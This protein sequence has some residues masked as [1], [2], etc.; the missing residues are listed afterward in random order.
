MID[1]I[2]KQTGADTSPCLFTRRSPRGSNDFAIPGRLSSMICDFGDAPKQRRRDRAPSTGQDDLCCIY[3]VCIWSLAVVIA[4]N[5]A[6]AETTRAAQSSSIHVVSTRHDRRDGPQDMPSPPS[7][8]CGSDL[9]FLPHCRDEAN[10]D[11]RSRQRG[12]CQVAGTAQLPTTKS[13]SSVRS[14][15]TRKYLMIVIIATACVF[16]TSQGILILECRPLIRA[17]ECVS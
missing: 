7:P 15:S 5:H 9:P 14:L 13:P 1:S 6:T 3:Q 11:D 2:V 8:R 10:E 4:S 17:G 12:F 16:R